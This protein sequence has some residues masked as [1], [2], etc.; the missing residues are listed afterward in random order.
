[1]PWGTI[2]ESCSDLRFCG[3]PLRN[4][5]IDLLL[6]MQAVRSPGQL[7]FGGPSSQQRLAGAVRWLRGRRVR[8]GGVHRVAV[9]RRGAGHGWGRRA[10][11]RAGRHC[12]RPRPQA[13]RHDRQ[14]RFPAPADA[15]GRGAAAECWVP[16]A[17]ILEY[18]ALLEAY[19]DPRREHAAQAQLRGVPTHPMLATR[20]FS[21]EMQLARTGYARRTATSWTSGD[22]PLGKK[23][24]L[25]RSGRSMTRPH[26][27]ALVRPTVLARSPG[28]GRQ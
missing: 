22:T 14:D 10:C 16:P 4:R 8:D 11:R 27:T 25:A 7:R 12:R 20:F 1:M 18:R 15:A 19:H 9:C 6:T 21:S 28:A 13:A 3:A 23:S 5:T 2:W 26:P 24:G 17:Q